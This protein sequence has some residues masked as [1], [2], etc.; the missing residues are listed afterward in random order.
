MRIKVVFHKCQ[1]ALEIS[2][3]SR[4]LIASSKDPFIAE[5]IQ[6]PDVQLFEESIIEGDVQKVKELVSNGADVNLTSLNGMNM[7]ILSLEYDHGEI[8][9]YLISKGA[10]IDPADTPLTPL[11]AALETG[12][13]EVIEYFLSNGV[14]VNRRGKN[15]NS[16]PIHRVVTN[17]DDYGLY[18]RF[19]ECGADITL[20]DG[21]G[22]TPLDIYNF[23]DND[24]NQEIKRLLTPKTAG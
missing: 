14:N 17:W 21:N 11:E 8:A 6:K 12:D 5:D 4:I 7:L 18:K 19:I 23:H 24:N 10:H 22:D 20:V 9:K 3:S 16:Y 2:S 15:E 1:A 13:I